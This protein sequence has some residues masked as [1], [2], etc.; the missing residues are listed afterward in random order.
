MK[1]HT[2]HLAVCE[3]GGKFNK[4]HNAI[5]NLQEEPI[6]PTGVELWSWQR[7]FVFFLCLHLFILLHFRKTTVHCSFLWAVSTETLKSL[8]QPKM[9]S[10]MLCFC[11][12]FLLVVSVSQP[13]RDVSSGVF[14]K[15]MVAL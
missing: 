1:I 4:T 12:V 7:C 5:Y 2:K 9:S 14:P 3:K 11:S 8:F 10:P 15:L 6:E 13:A